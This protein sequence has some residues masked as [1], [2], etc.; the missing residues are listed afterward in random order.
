MTE[1]DAKLKAFFASTNG[2]VTEEE[3]IDS[4]RLNPQGRFI[5]VQRFLKDK[6]IEN[7]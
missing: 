5:N 7:D 4:T 3:N 6:R 1:R 2:D